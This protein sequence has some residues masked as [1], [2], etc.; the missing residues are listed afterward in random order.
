VLAVD[1]YHKK[2]F[3]FAM[4]RIEKLQQFLADN[5]GDSFVRHALALE[6]C[7]LGND[8]EARRLFEELLARDPGYTGSYYHL[9]RLLE[10]N[11]DKDAAITVYERGMEETKKAGDNHAYSELRSAYEELVF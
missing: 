7:K 5:P 2:D 4:D 11:N 10:R 9:A 3:F 8:R 6:Y 1:Y